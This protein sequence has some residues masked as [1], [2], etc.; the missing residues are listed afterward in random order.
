MRTARTRTMA[1]RK[2]G[3]PETNG[4]ESGALTTIYW[5]AKKNAPETV[6]GDFSAIPADASAPAEP[7]SAP[8]PK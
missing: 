5:D 8:A 1:R 3:T 7:A 4:R 2:P 6:T